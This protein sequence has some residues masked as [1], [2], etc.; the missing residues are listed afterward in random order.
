MYP[1]SLYQNMSLDDSLEQIYKKMYQEFGPQ[2]WWPADSDYET[3]VG[4]ILTQSVSWTN[5]EKA[6]KNLKEYSG[7]LDKRS[8]GINIITPELIKEID[9]ELL[10]ELIKPSGYYNMKA[11]KLKAFVE[12][13][14]QE[15]NG[16]LDFMFKE[17]L[18]VLRSKLLEVYG[19]GPETA[20][21]ILLYAGKYPIFVIDAYTKR[22]LSRIGLTAD[23]V[24]YHIL[25]EKVMGNLKTNVKKY[26]EYHALIVEL[27]KNT[28]TKSNPKCNICVLAE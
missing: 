15:Y 26:N 11:K 24:D 4:A 7:S 10:A 23:D 1:C 17:E 16:D 13:L 2:E 25:Q 12:F 22:I 5:V 6:I 19:I 9:I 27:G 20:D 21:S 18:K 3:T 28:C 14:Y 8:S